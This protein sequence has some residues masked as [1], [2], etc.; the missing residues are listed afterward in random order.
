MTLARFLPAALLICSLPAFS[1]TQQTRRAHT[2]G[3][4][5][6][7]VATNRDA[8]AVSSEPWKIIP[9]R[10]PDL[11]PDSP[12]RLRAD[13]Y[14]WEQGKVDFGNGHSKLGPKADVLVSGLGADPTCYAIRSYLVARDAKDSDST[15]PVG[16]STCQPAS[17]YHLKSAQQDAESSP[18]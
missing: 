9:T 11:G 12:D 6:S 8:M 13:Q 3:D 15:H 10:P 5:V 17:R 4:S 16:Y 7:S 2:H 18:R 1:Q 14:R